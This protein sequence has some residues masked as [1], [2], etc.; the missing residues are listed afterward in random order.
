MAKYP[1]PSPSWGLRVPPAS[2]GREGSPS[3]EL[4]QGC[5]GRNWP[6]PV[7][8]RG[9]DTPGCTAGRHG[10]FGG[11]SYPISIKAGNRKP[12]RAPPGPCC[13]EQQAGPLGV[14]AVGETPTCFG[15]PPPLDRKLKGAANGQERRHRTCPAAKLGSC[16]GR[17]ICAQRL[18]LRSPT[19]LCTPLPCPPLCS[20]DQVLLPAEPSPRPPQSSAVESCSPGLYGPKGHLPGDWRQRLPES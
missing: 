19:S 11:E 13:R 6:D 7:P 1:L 2:W 18:C 12:K 9:V 3:A 8:G 10:F 17:R 5:A 14:T 20:V 4:C 15:G 16:R